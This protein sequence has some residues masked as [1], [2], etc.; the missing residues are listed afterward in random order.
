MRGT[1][2]IHRRRR[3]ARMAVAALI[4]CLFTATTDSAEEDG[5]YDNRVAVREPTRLDWT[6]VVA[7]QSVVEPLREWLDRANDPMQANDST[8]QTYELY[9][10]AK[11]IAGGQLYPLVLFV[12][13]D[14]QAIGW[15][16]WEAVCRQHGLVFAGP[17]GA[18]DQHKPSHRF[19]VVL[20][21]LGDVR[22]GHPID[23]DRTY[24]C[25]LSNGAHIACE[26]GYSL[27][28]CF[29]GVIAIG[30][31]EAPPDTLWLRHQLADRLSVAFLVRSRDR[32]GKM[33]GIRSRDRTQLFVESMFQ[34]LVAECGTRSKLRSYSAHKHH[35]PSSV[36]AETVLWAED[37]TEERRELASNFPSSRIGTEVVASREKRA[38][39]TLKDAKKRL[40]NAATF[41]A[42]LLQLEGLRQRWPDVAA[43]M[44]AERILKGYEQRADRPWQDERR[45]ERSQAFWANELAFNRLHAAIHGHGRRLLPSR[46]HAYPE[47]YAEMTWLEPAVAGD[48]A[49]TGG[50]KYDDAAQAVL[51]RLGTRVRF[52]DRGRVN[53]VDL[54]GTLV[55][56]RQFRNLMKQLQ[57][58]TELRSLNLSSTSMRGSV[59]THVA[60]L[61]SLR[62]L[63]LTHTGLTN[64][65][66]AHLAKLEQLQFLA[67]PYTD[68]SNIN[69]LRSL[70]ELRVLILGGTKIGDGAL[71]Q[72][73]AAS[74]LQRLS[75]YSTR[76]TDKG[77]A[78]LTHFPRLTHLNLGST[79][80]TNAACPNLAQHVSLEG[81]VLDKTDIADEGL[82]EL[83][84]LNT[85][86]SLS[87]EETGI[88]DAGLTVIR[89][90]EHLKSLNVSKTQ[91]TERGVDDLRGFLPAC[92]LQWDGDETNDSK[93]EFA[94]EDLYL[95]QF[96]DQYR[97]KLIEYQRRYLGVCVRGDEGV[98]SR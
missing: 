20:D 94:N 73:A 68:V 7:K 52:N 63:N 91:V 71:D 1:I 81:L 16:H 98:G 24:I 19:R 36:L 61:S 9:L 34:P 54:S 95:N 72:L 21:V 29:G 22:R 67:I 50:D 53:R 57:G 47:E 78:K 86:R 41:Y 11:N 17:H 51:E 93:N 60:G 35:I 84:R 64:G 31:G 33:I 49:L 8:T 66:M 39:A 2:S 13:P 28:E 56:A 92:Q 87:L 85:L 4:V 25:G 18:G 10:P 48:A 90:M 23:P 38:Q 62:A 3:S 43:A 32:D 70:R 83:R 65:G 42:G 59:L 58:M 5:V 74:N 40:S 45:S 76:V 12:S 27:P 55:T 75:L 30:G 26:I 97:R 69:K 88:T 15:K 37:A 89:G 82:A 46:Y 44:E 14:K 77:V 80:V 6:F 79:Q 96:E